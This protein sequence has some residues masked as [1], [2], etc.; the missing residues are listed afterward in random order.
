MSTVHCDQHQTLSESRCRAKTCSQVTFNV[1]A[2]KFFDADLQLTLDLH[3]QLSTIGD[4]SFPVAAAHN[5]NTLC[6]CF[7]R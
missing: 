3:T 4:R 2:N 1:T 7:P 6:V 5:W